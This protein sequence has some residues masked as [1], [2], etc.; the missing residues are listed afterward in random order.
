MLNVTHT[1]AL[2][3][4]KRPPVEQPE[5]F[6]YYVKLTDGESKEDHVV[7][8]AKFVVNS[9]NGRPL[10]PGHRLRAMV[11]ARLKADCHDQGG[12][13]G[14]SSGVVPVETLQATVPDDWHITAKVLDA[15][16]CDII[17]GWDQPPYTSRRE[18]EYVHVLVA[19]AVAVAVALVVAVAVAV[20]VCLC[21]AVRT[22]S[23]RCACNR[24][25]LRIADAHGGHA[26]KGATE[27]YTV[28]G[29]SNRYFLDEFNGEPIVPGDKFHVNV[30]WRY[31]KDRGEGDRAWTG[32]SGLT[33]ACT[34]NMTEPAALLES[35]VPRV[36]VLRPIM[37]KT[38]SDV[39][40]SGAE[41]LP[42]VANIMMEHPDMALGVEG[43]VNYGQK[44]ASALRLS[45]K[46]A[47]R[48]VSVLVQQGVALARLKPSGHGYERPRFPRG[49]EAAK[50]NRRVEFRVL[51]GSGLYERLAAAAQARR[52]A[53]NVS[54]RLTKSFRGSPNRS[55]RTSSRRR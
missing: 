46:R 54:L 33:E 13:W 21:G 32:S 52:D 15:S 55:L 14:H 28:A 42:G 40:T 31:L 4:W 6:E 19:V 36:F 5:L 29:T 7:P 9:F 22:F 41:V 50:L 11:E 30:R 10:H 43:H 26:T 23:Q 51:P 17:V 48:V 18:I 25:C 27:E 53:I 16:L 45:S 3:K 39:I 8:D 1:S 24:Y 44:P 47:K 2:L 37:F 49:S 35:R 38:N 34:L 12:G 20:A